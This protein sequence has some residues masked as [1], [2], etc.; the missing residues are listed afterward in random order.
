MPTGRSAVVVI[1]L[2]AGLGG[3]DEGGRACAIETIGI[4]HDLS[5]C[6]TAS[7]AG[8]ARIRADV[9]TFPLKQLNGKTAGLIASPPCTDFSMAGRRAG[10][11]GETGKLMHQVP[12]WV[13]ALRPRWVAC[14]QVP[15][16]LE[17][18]EMFAA[19]FRTVGYKTW[20]G[21]LNA[22]DYGVP[23]TRQRAFLL[24]SL[25][26]QPQP[27]QRTH[28]RNPQPDLFGN[29][30]LPWV[31]MAD[32]L[33][34]GATERP[35][36]ML[37]ERTE[38][39]SWVVRT[40]NN[41]RRAAGDY[42]D[43]RETHA[44]FERSVAEPAPTVDGKFYFTLHTNRGQDENGERQ[45]RDSSAPAPALSAKAGGQWWWQKPSTTVGGDPRVS[46]RCH[47]DEGMQGK[48][49]LPAAAAAA[50]L[51]DNEQP[52]RLTVRDALIL[53][54]FPPDYPMRGTK[55]KQFEQIGNA[56]PPL[57]AMHVLRTLL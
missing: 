22:A 16:A 24:A 46:P 57:L 35:I 10:I 15:P 34:W 43:W 53:Q 52:I 9:T 20:T 7:A 29:E 54:S 27:P 39:H 42:D 14:E 1:D 55:T 38:G 25:D 11:D 28:A 17:W 30:L 8:H 37:R 5:A 21:I 26:R 2:C 23:Q 50:G 32:A 6:Q 12:R 56:V 49:A 18:W 3:W 19:E 45:T 51:G 31:S 4:E 44:P 48:N 41:S 33:G 36:A 13:H 47:H 40:G